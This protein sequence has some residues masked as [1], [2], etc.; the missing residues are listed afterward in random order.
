MNCSSD[1][2]QDKTEQINFSRPDDDDH[3]KDVVE[4]E[5]EGDDD[6]KVVEAEK[7]RIHYGNDPKENKNSSS[8]VTSMRKTTDDICFICGVSLSKIKHRVAHFKRCQ[9][10]FG[11]TGKDV[12]TVEYASTSNNDDDKEDTNNAS[13]NNWHGDAEKMLIN[14]KHE[15]F[16]DAEAS[17]NFPS[18]INVSRGNCTR[19]LNN[20]LMAGSRRLE[21]IAKATKNRGDTNEKRGNKR[22]RFSSTKESWR[23]PLYKKITSTDFVVDG[24]HYAKA[25]LTSNYFLSHYHSDHYGGIS[26]SWDAGTIYCSLP[27]AKL[28]SQ[29]LR[30]NKKFLHPL[31]LNQATVILSRGKPITVTLLDANHCKLFN[32]RY[33]AVAL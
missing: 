2:I 12:R 29:Q 9:K 10:K 8:R 16:Y 30:V 22:A 14:D 15:G 3:D 25:S 21:I 26:S 23:C 32:S 1:T 5:S 28:V 11:I 19:N 27:T 31:E 4:E 6:C 18:T 13:D 24:F 20:V 17:R 7:G 33:I